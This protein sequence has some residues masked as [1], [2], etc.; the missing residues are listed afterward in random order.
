[1]S[2]PEPTATHGARPGSVSAACGLLYGYAVLQ[3]ASAALVLLTIADLRSALR[4][5]Y[6][7]TDFA[8]QSSVIATV[9]AGVSIAGAILFA[10]GAVVLAVLD[11]RG[12]NPAR[13]VTWVFGG[14]GVCCA[15]YAVSSALVGSMMNF[16]GQAGSGAPSAGEVQR[17]LRDN[18]PG[19]YYPANVTVGVLEVLTL[20]LVIALLT[21]PSANRFFRR[22]A[23]PA[24]EP[25]LPPAPTR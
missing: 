5:A 11:G 17:I 14:L 15:G 8:D 3:L 7:S 19:W 25:P 12:K 18:L 2:Y 22:P 4:Q 6:A 23:Q 24:W 9:G 10:A 1:M 16:G 20:I 13:I 21:V